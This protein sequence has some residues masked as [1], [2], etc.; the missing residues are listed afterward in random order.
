M[1]LIINWREKKLE[2]V[3]FITQMETRVAAGASDLS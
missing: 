1:V 2:G 3:V